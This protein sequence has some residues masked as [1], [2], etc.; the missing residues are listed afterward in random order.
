MSLPYEILGEYTGSVESASFL[1]SKDTSLLYVSNSVDIWFS[2]SIND[3][4]EIGAFSTDDQTPVSWGV[5]Y[6]DKDFQTVN[7]TYID[8]RNVPYSYSYNQLINPFTLHG[9]DSI[10][11]QPSSDLNN[12]GITEGSYVVSYNFTREMAGTPS[13]S[14]TIKDI[15][16]SRTEVKLIPSN[17]ADIQYNS[18]CVKKFPIRDV[19]PVLLSLSK[20][21]SY[22]EIYKE[23]SNLNQYD[24]GISF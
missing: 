19:A 8:Y 7:L 23:M 3:T 2:L 1:S 17:T 6:Q 15:S 18:F 5:L 24:N 10:L 4:I 22:D 12:I 20:N 16:P 9:N 11:L 13:S 14:L 21:I